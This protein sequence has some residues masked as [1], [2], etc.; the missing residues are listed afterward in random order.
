LL[1]LV[2]GICGKSPNVANAGHEP[3]ALLRHGREKGY[4]ITPQEIAHLIR[5][6]VPDALVEAND[7]TGTHDHYNVRVVSSR[8]ADMALLDRHRLVY[9]ALDP[10]LKDGRLHAVQLKTESPKAPEASRT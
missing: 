1:L 10:A 2:I 6:V 9:A 3:E 7:Y 5:G 8:F 4:V